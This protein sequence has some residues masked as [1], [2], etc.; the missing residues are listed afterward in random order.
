MGVI[1]MTKFHCA[2]RSLGM[3]EH[4]IPDTEWFC[5]M[6][7]YVDSSPILNRFRPDGS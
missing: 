4:A 7:S 3:G 2:S 6:C 5:K 1:F